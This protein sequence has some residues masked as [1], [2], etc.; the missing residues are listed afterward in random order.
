MTLDG[1]A[2]NALPG[3]L[4]IPAVAAAVFAA[5]PNYWAAARLNGMIAA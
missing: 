5:L 1:L 4:L 3:V 2:V